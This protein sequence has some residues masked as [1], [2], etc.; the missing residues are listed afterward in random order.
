MFK[1]PP[2]S[3]F[4]KPREWN[5]KEWWFCGKETGGKCNGEYRRHKPSE[6]KG[7]AFMMTRKKVTENQKETEN[8]SRHTTRNLKVSEALS[9]VIEADGND[10]ESDDSD[11]YDS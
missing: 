3:E 1:A 10:T 7:K 2:E 6:C 4:H 11:A 5:G 9:T 8:P